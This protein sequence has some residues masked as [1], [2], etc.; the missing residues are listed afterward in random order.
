MSSDRTNNDKGAYEQKIDQ[1]TK[2][3]SWL[4][5]INAHENCNICD[6]SENPNVIDHATR[7]GVE[8]E[9]RNL[10]N[11]LTRDSTKKHQFGDKIPDTAYSPAWLCERN[12][13]SQNKDVKKAEE[14]KK[15]MDSLRNLS[16]TD[17]F[18]GNINEV[19]NKL[20]KNGV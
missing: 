19:L 8:S 20:R 10:D 2:P 18:P 15:Y 16:P 5:D 17:P 9:I 12:L 3:L 4:F 1:V 14:G 13:S 6:R 7:V 11:K